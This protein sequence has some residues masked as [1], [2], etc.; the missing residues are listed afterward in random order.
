MSSTDPIADMLTQ[1]RNAIMVN[2][3]SISLPYSAM[4]EKI[5]K[6]LA[7]NDFLKS[8]STDKEAK[9]KLLVISIND[10]HLPAAISEIKR[11]SRPGKRSYVKSGA[12]PVVKR[13]RGIV[14]LSTSQGLM[15]GKDAKAKKLGGEVVFEVY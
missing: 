9:D 8:V 3:D 14:V 1:I 5:A 12:I 13:G 4:K 6:I 11:I 15:T 2:K 7:D 10:P